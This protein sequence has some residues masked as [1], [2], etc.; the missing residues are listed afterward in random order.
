MFRRLESTLPDDFDFPTDLE[1]LG[2]FINEHDQIRMICDPSQGFHY[3]ISRNDRYVERQKEA[4][5]GM[6]E[7]YQIYPR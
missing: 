3:F 6:L 5:N 4:M 2:Y 7:L 1:G